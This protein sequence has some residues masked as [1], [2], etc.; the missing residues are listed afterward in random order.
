MDH[1]ET[2]TQIAAAA[3]LDEVEAVRITLL[4]KQGSISALLKTLGAMSPDE[5]QAQGPAIQALREAAT[6]AIAARKAELEAAA[7]DLRLAAEMLDLTLPAPLE[8]VGTIHPV[9]Q[10][11]DE[12][13]ESRP[14]AEQ[15]GIAEGDPDTV[16]KAPEVIRAYLGEKA[17]HA[18]GA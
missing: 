9:S 10:V 7:L 8:P 11:L 3:T 2:L 16:R 1:A 18:F 14:L 17:A 12:L 5:R 4:G 15:A 6:A 13:A